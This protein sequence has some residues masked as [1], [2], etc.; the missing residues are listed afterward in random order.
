[1]IHHLKGALFV[2]CMLAVQAVAFAQAPGKPVRVLVG[3]PPGAVRNVLF[4]MSDPLR[5]DHLSC[6]GHPARWILSAMPA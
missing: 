5:A 1:M 3:F 2:Y 6:R 4:I